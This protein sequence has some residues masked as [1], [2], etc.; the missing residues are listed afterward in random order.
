MLKTKVNKIA[1]FFISFI[2]MMSML[3]VLPEKRLEVS[4]ATFNDINASNVFLRQE[5][6]STCTLTSS[7][8]MLRRAAMMRGD[9]NWNS[10]TESS[11]RSTAWIEGQGLKWD[12]TYSNIRVQYSAMTPSENTLKSLLNEHPEGIVA[13]NRSAP[14]AVLLTDYTNG[15]F[16]CADPLKDGRILLTNSYT[17]RV[18]NI[19]GYWYV[20][21]PKVSL[22][23][24]PSTPVTHSPTG[25]V[26][27]AAGGAG[28]ITISGW[29]QD[30]DDTS[31]P[32][33]INVYKDS[34]SQG[35]GLAGG[36]IA[37]RDRGDGTHTGFEA[38]FPV[39][40]AGTYHI[41]V[42]A[43][44]LSNTGGNDWTIIGDMNVVVPVSGEIINLGDNFDASIKS[45]QSS[46][47]IITNTSSSNVFLYG[48]PA[49]YT[50][51]YWNFARQSDGSYRIKAY[52]N[53][54]YMDVDGA[55]DEDGRNVQS[56]G[57]NGGG[58]AQR[59][60]IIRSG[61]NYVLRPACSSARV[62]DVYGAETK[63]GSNLSISQYN[64]GAN[65]QVIIEKTLRANVVNLGDNFDATITNTGSGKFVIAS[66][67]NNNVCL[68]DTSGGSYA[69]KRIWNFARQSD[70]SYKITSYF[71]SKCLDVNGGQDANSNVGTYAPNNSNA[72]KWYIVKNGSNYR[73]M[74]ACSNT[75][76]L[77]IV[78]GNTNTA[79]GTNIQIFENNDTNAQSFKINKISGDT[80]KPTVSKIEIPKAS[81]TVNGY[82]VIIT[83]SD[84][85][86][87][88]QIK[89]PTWTKE[90]GN[91]GQDDLKWHIATQTGQNTW[92]Y[93]VKVSEHNNERG[94]YYTDVYAYDFSGNETK[95]SG[96]T[97]HRSTVKVGL[98]NLTY[99]PN[100]GSAGSESGK[101]VT[102]AT[103]CT[104]NQLIYNGSNFTS[105]TWA[106]PSRSG[107]TFTGWYTAA[108]GGTKIYDADGKCVNE[109]KYFKNNVYIYSGD[110]KIYAQWT[111]TKT[112]YNFTVDPNGGTM[113]DK[114]Y[115][116]NTTKAVTYDTKLQYNNS[117][118]YSATSCIPTRTGYTFTGFYTAAAGGTKI[119]GAD[120]KC[121][122]E[123]KYFKDNKYINV[124]DLKVYAQWTA[125]SYTIAYNA[126]GGSGTTKNTAMT[127]DKNANLTANG[128]TKTGY[129][130]KNWNTKAD[131]SGTAY[132]DKASVKNLAA[133]GTVTLYAQWTANSYT[134][135]YNANGGSGTTKNTAMTYDKNA[136]LTANGFTKTGYTF[137]NWNTKADGSGTAYADKASVKNLAASGTVTLYAQWKKEEP[138]VT[139][140]VTKAK[141]TTTTTTTSKKVTTGTTV[142]TTTVTVDDT[143]NEKSIAETGDINNDGTLNVADIV[144]LQKYLMK[145]YPMTNEQRKSSDMNN[146]GNVNVFDMVILKRKL[147]RM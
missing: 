36:I 85:V 8:M 145:S 138:K 7:A 74:P 83:A 4:A 19:T 114:D 146:D 37:N 141:T 25:N 121:V 31:R 98:F 60:F 58:S 143:T 89:V 123:G 93:N 41:L 122:N 3:A 136:N 30:Y 115:K 51:K 21:S 10:I 117:T 47:Y 81:I 55:I 112:S 107:Y 17:V 97:G 53:G 54:K 76:S 103:T 61:N 70:N 96:S 63:D 113:K 82:K 78:G 139:T 125:N 77:D 102:G 116:N 132:A 144:I 111:P 127:Y 73:L 57:D 126:N 94:I 64:G 15:N 13:Y 24:Q 52:C 44:N 124:T 27:Y 90:G 56:W 71:N 6:K 48:N 142:V 32:V 137:K 69:S 135:A 134:I 140:V 29:A 20:S 39:G 75:R 49:G 147:M 106:K 45:V 68:Y 12:F 130:F 67:T 87:I 1:A 22:S 91:S 129:T 95:C 66:A 42:F 33:E 9:S 23:T 80:T 100:G 101:S 79:N 88:K 59:W 38:S 62:L 5:G 99:D 128:F 14:H 86:G 50:E 133:S 108:T 26:E 109:G 92:E 72:Q 104:K 16:Y 34:L 120:G 110:L 119:Y 11:L 65:Q 84:N 2:M 131:G 28:T 118:W 18:S 105:M 40:N 35:N 43:L 46:K